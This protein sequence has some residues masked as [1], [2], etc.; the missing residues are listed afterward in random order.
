LELD[1]EVTTLDS[2]ELAEL[3]EALEWLEE[4]EEELI[5]DPLLLADA[6]D[7]LLLLELLLC[8]EL[9]LLREE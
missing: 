6:E 4:D 9:A 7:R 3:L 8:G 1:D 2:W 5:E